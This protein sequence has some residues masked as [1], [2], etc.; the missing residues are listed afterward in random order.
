MKLRRNPAFVVFWSAR[1]LSYLGT[2]ITNIVLPV[3]VYQLTGS[4]AAVALVNGIEA[5]PYLALGLLAGALAPLRPF[6]CW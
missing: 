3:L 1:T 5:V 6:T 2:G 4:P